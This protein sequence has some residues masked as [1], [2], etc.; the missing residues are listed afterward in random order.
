VKKLIFWEK[1]KKT[2]TLAEPQ[3]KTIIGAGCAKYPS[4][5][6]ER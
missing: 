1:Q 6:P 4:N 3:Q 5:S 2:K